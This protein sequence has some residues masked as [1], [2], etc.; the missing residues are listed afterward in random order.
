MDG[1]QVN[2]RI[3]SEIYDKIRGEA[4]NTSVSVNTIIINILNDYFK[5]QVL[6][7]EYGD[8]TI[9][10]STLKRILN[11]TDPKLLDIHTS[12][13]ADEKLAEMR[14]TIDVVNRVEMHKMIMKWHDMNGLK[15]ASF[16]NNERVKYVSKHNLGDTWS[17]FECYIHKKM[18][19]KIGETVTNFE[20][21]AISYTLEIANP[22][23]D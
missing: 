11:N 23:T 21:D 16:V 3:P 4:I 18:F 10:R 5:K 9:F 8:I 15:I 2:P 12:E 19:E 22:K 17:K 6:K 13:I 1:K 14:L 20:Y 7:N